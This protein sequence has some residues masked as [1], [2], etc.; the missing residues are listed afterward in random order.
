MLSG[1]TYLAAETI[2][3]TAQ[4]PAVSYPVL[5]ALVLLGSVL[6][7]VPT[8]AVV[9]AAAAL[10]MTS[11]GELSTLIVV[12]LAATAAFAGDSITFAVCRVGGPRVLRWFR[13]SKNATAVEEARDRL[14][15]HGAR[16]LIVARLIPA[17]RIPS[18]LAAGALKYPW[19]RFLAGCAVA[20]TVW[21]SLYALLGVISGGIFDNPT[22]GVIAAIVIVFVVS[23]LTRLVQKWWRAR[24]ISAP[25]A[26]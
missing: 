19:H 7:V 4:E 18:L 8:G 20:V 13:Q 25:A 11:G 16:F 21:A 26:T 23:V 14:S 15:Y 5:V 17:G 10:A 1:L 9:S 2:E 22:Q 24:H 6:P 12:V 3:L